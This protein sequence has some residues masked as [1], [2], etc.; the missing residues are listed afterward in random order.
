MFG[1][2]TTLLLLRAAISSATS[3]KV[4][5]Y[6]LTDLWEER[7]LAERHLFPSKNSAVYPA[8][9][10]LPAP[11]GFS[12]V[13]LS[14]GAVE[15]LVRNLTASEYLVHSVC[16][17]RHLNVTFFAVNTV[18]GAGW[19][20]VLIDANMSVVEEKMAEMTARRVKVNFICVGAQKDAY[21]AVWHHSNEFVW[22]Y[23]VES[24]PVNDIIDRD[25]LQLRRGY[26]PDCFQVY[27]EDNSSRAIVIWR[28]GFGKRYKL[29]YG[30]ELEEMVSHM[31]NTD[32]TPVQLATLPRQ[33]RRRHWSSTELSMNQWLLWHGDEFSWANSS[34]PKNSH[35]NFWT[36]LDDMIEH[37]MRSYDIPSVS[38]FVMKDGKELYSAAYGYVDVIKR[39]EATPSHRYR[40]ASVSKLITAIGIG[41][42]VVKYKIDLMQQ[43]FAENGLLSEFCQPCH[44]FLKMI[45]II[46]LLEHSSGAWPHTKKFEFERMEL[47][48]TE[49]LARAVQEEL[50]QFQPGTR[51][52]Y[53]NI[54]YIILGKIIETVSN[55]TYEEFVNENVLQPLGINAT[56]GKDG[57]SGVEATY[58]SQ[59]NANAYTSWN[60]KRMNSAA[61]W[62]M[63]AENVAKL[64]KYLEKNKHRK[65]RWLVTP[66][67][68]R[69]N[70]GRGVQLG[71][72]G[73]LY[74]IGSLAGTEAIG[75]SWG[76]VQVAILTNI[77]GKEQNEQTGW[78]ESV[79]RSIADGRLR[80]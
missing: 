35:N 79:C 76:N 41:E 3:P 50:P 55:K 10:A 18:R 28:K 71:F 21:S 67:F 42:L 46:N 73:S 20:E 7:G 74:H 80:H 72:D 78:M 66:S 64:F 13:H 75:Y 5:V 24:G 6:S 12:R 14:R 19:S 34:I 49:F 59:D 52:L 26:Y 2:L 32:L 27:R 9:V 69:W 61:G 54:G 39:V 38:I 58:Y 22:H 65:F 53:S 48:Q 51:H 15:D 56:I 36:I 47:N 45:R 68:V 40:I 44:P 43:I 30:T 57:D 17:Y 77:R 60:P 37:R 1:C 70:Y 62:S 25:A 11:E 31:N 8:F 29:Q 16:S 4:V 63:T 33:A 23:V